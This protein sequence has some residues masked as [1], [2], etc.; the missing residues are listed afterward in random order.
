MKQWYLLYCKR[1]EQQRAK[2]HLENQGVECYYPKT[3]IEKIVR[4]KRQLRAEPLFPSYVFVRFDSEVGPTFTTLRST[5]GVVDFVRQ[6]VRP[7]I[8]QGDLIYTMK[9]AEQ[10]Q[11]E[12]FQTLIPAL[13]ERVRIGKGEFAGF[14]AIY[15]QPDGEMRSILLVELLSTLVPVSIDNIYLEI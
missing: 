11:Q 8:L 1:G 2:L 12:T 9:Q 13:G 3:Q 7:Q 14:E 15:Q 6:G 4:G 10:S 5:R